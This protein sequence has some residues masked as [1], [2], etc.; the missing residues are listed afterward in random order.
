MNI[1]FQRKLSAIFCAIALTSSYLI[2]IFCDVNGFFSASG[3]LL[4]LAGI[5]LS[6]KVSNIFHKE[7][8]K[9]QF[10]K[11]YPSSGFSKEYSDEE[12]QKYIQ[13]I[14]DDEWYGL[15]FVFLGTIIWGYGSYF[16]D[17]TKMPVLST[18]I[19]TLDLLQNAIGSLL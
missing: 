11:V 8:I 2:E 12:M 14:I 10:D 18:F 7:T 5:L 4:S 6:I 3:S 15:C 9:K 17:Y 1:F 19:S 13:P 16:I